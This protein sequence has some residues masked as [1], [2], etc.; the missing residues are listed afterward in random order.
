MD[1]H[2]EGRSR[3]RV[4]ADGREGEHRRGAEERE[5]RVGARLLRV[6]DEERARCDER[7]CDDARSPG[8]EDDPGAVRD[9]DRRRPRERGER[10]QANL[11]E[12][13][14]LR[15]RPGHD[16]VEVRRRL[17]PRDLA[18][19]VREAAIEQRR[20][21]E[22]VEPEALPVEGGEAQDGAEQGERE[23]RPVP[24]RGRAHQA[25][26]RRAGPRSPASAASA[27]TMKSG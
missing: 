2:R 10:P 12:P 25:D 3:E 26:E 6:P 11:A 5:Q 24:R 15:P 8:H 19:D 14:D 18:E 9:R 27:V 23:D 16:V 4:H 22:L 21:D 7:G 20:R 17:G 1:E 13:E